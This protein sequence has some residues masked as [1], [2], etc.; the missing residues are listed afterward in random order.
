MI[1]IIATIILFI[2]GIIGAFG[3]KLMRDALFADV[4]PILVNEGIQFFVG[5]IMFLGGL[6]FIGGFIYHRDKKR[7]LVKKRSNKL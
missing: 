2:P 4:Y 1:R 5:L 7:Q 6:A 3:I